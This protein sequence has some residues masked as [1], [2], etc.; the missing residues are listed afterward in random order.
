[1]LGAFVGT[2]D[3]DPDSLGVDAIFPAFFLILLL[4]ELRR[5]GMRSVALM[6]ALIAVVLV[7]ITP[8]GVPVLV[9]SGAALVGLRRGPHEAAPDWGEL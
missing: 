5:P 8:I 9:A 3:I 7:P 1:V 4:D 6:G 2:G